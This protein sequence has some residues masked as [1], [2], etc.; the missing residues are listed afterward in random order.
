MS[1]WV[2]SLAP[3]YTFRSMKCDYWASLLT[4]TF[5]SLYFGRKPKVKVAIDIILKKCKNIINNELNF[6]TILMDF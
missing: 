4:H 5:A 3:S 1:V 2:H 6:K